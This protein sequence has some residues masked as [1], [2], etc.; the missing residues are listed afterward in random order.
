M[1]LWEFILELLFPH[2]CIL[3]GKLL[4]KGQQDLCP[5]CRADSPDYPNRK[6]KIQFLD[7]FTAVWYY[8]GSVRRSLLRYKFYSMRSYADSYGRLLAMKVLEIHPEGFDCLTW[9]PVSRR[10]KI[11]RGYDQVQLL[12]KAVGRELGLT[13]VPL[14]KKVRHNRPQSGIADAAM[15]RANVLGAYRAEN[16]EQI[17][18]K[19]I[20]LLDDVLT[21]GSTAGECAR[22]LLT[23]GAK[24]V[25]CAAIAAVRK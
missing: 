16:R 7:S 8:E 21:T 5:D 11:R 23:C 22:V 6:E 19:R 3:C 13:P 25:H 1:K 10:R 15:R 2:K 20:L 4:E 18:G 24:E 12:A 9:V 14:L 17:A